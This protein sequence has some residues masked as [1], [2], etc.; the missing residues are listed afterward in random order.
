MILN[1]VSMD[2]F[3]FGFGPCNIVRDLLWGF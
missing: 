1:F 3:D 2:L